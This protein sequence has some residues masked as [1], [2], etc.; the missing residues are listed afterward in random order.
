VKAV[1]KELRGES[2]IENRDLAGEEGRRAIVPIIEKVR[3]VHSRY[4][5]I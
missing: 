1:L 2:T 3:K 4:W 5:E